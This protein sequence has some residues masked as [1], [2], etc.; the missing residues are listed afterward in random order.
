MKT[1]FNGLFLSQGSEEGEDTDL[2]H[3]HRLKTKDD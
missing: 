1:E 3:I 2:S